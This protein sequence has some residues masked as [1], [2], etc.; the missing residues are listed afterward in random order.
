MQ[1]AQASS[2]GVTADAVIDLAI[3]GVAMP[4]SEAKVGRVT[5]AFC[6]FLARGENEILGSPVT[7]FLTPPCQAASGTRFAA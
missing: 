7:A 4:D 3:G 5:R 6:N 2:G 1:P